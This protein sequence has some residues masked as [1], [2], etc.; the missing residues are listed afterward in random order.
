VRT[1]KLNLSPQL[2]NEMFISIHIPKT[3]GTALGY[4]FDHGSGRRV[5]W[6]YATDYSNAITLDPLF[7]ENSEF[8]RKYFWG[9]HGHFYYRKYND[10]FSDALYISC[11]RHPV[12]RLASHFL[13]ELHES[14]LGAKTWRSEELRTGKMNFVDFVCSDETTRLSQLLHLEG[15][16]PRHYDFLFVDTLLEAGIEAFEKKFAF[17]RRDPYA[18]KGIPRMNENR[19]REFPDSIVR[20]QF[21]K[22]SEISEAERVAVYNLIPEEVEIFRQGYEHAKNLI[23]GKA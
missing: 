7:T 4:V 2:E 17:F 19:S 12:D 18:F 23:Q 3:A 10:T 14:L 1:R 11:I 20:A 9:I 13:H 5:L 6:D 8:I 22:L 15:R 16:E 21:L